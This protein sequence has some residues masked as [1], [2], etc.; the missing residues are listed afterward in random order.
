[1]YQLRPYQ[2]ETVTKV[3]N[4]I[5]AGHRSIIVQLPPR[6]GKTV[7]MAEIA[8]LATDKGNQ[9]LFLIHRKEVLEQAIKTFHEQSVNPDLLTAGMVQTLT[10]HVDRIK[11][12]QLI[13]VDEAH[14][15]LAVSYQRILQAFPKAYRLLFT[16]TP[17]RTGRKQ[18]DQVAD[19]IIVGKSI[20]ELTKAGY[21][22]PFRY[23]EPPENLN[24]SLLKKSSTGD[25][26]QKSIDQVMTSAVYGHTVK[27]YKRLASG[28]QAVVYASSISQ[29]KSIAQKFNAAGISASE[30]DGETPATDRDAIVENFR[31]QQLMVLVN[32]NLFTEG[33]DLPNVNCVIMA[34]PTA[35]LA[36]YLQFAMRCLNPRKGKTAVI[37]DHVKN[38]SRFGYPDDDRD[39]A[40]AIHTRDG[41]SPA[42]R[43]ACQQIATVTCDHCFAV[44]RRNEIQDG[45]CP[46]C[47][48]PIKVPEEVT[49]KD[50]DLVER[51][52]AEQRRE[53]IK[54]LVNDRVAL[55]VA[56][57]SVY[58]LHSMA[59][60]RAYARLKNYKPGWVY[61]AAKRKGLLK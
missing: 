59:E 2:I 31:Q 45:E 57:K 16:A 48:K 58:E 12:P 10:R 13:L 50:V 3:R 20:R 34:R 26:T 47:G 60:L 55:K 56:N 22:A 44:V 8:K 1:M 43:H 46:I 15:A 49:V 41:H 6:T 29:A 35:S 7:L 19:D 23:F 14:H 33:V 42:S 21:L 11:P 53:R 17:I 61:L 39:W 18:M 52:Q 32:V 40:N 9:V 51:K 5:K 25:F 24:W 28:K 36:L 27:Q 38:S 54:K 30:V 37:I 4:E